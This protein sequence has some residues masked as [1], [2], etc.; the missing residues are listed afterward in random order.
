M[1]LLAA[2]S[3]GIARAAETPAKPS[4]GPLPTQTSCFQCH[5]QLSEEALE[6]T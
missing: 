6:P 5:S 4:A 1:I 2:L 3:A